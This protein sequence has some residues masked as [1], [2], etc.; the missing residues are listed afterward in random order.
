[1]TDVRSVTV[2]GDSVMKGVVYDEKRRKYTLLPENGADRASRA[3]GLQLRNRARMGCTVTKGLTIVKKDL[4]REPESEAALIEF[5]GNDCDFDWSAVAADPD[6]KHLPK[7]PLPAFVSQLHELV[8]LVV[9]KGVRPVL[10]TL[11]PIHAERYFAF[12]TR[13]GDNGT[14]GLDGDH[15]LKWLGDVQFIYR[16]HE[17]Y[18]NAVARVAEECGCILADVREAFLGE[19]HYEDLLCVDGIHP[20]NRGHA[21]MEQVLENFG[22]T[23]RD[24]GLIAI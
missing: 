23:C 21:L 9:Q 17:R 14:P 4:T 6:G 1:M 15:I 18:S 5:G 24:K 2:W 20:N 11:P 7:T 13:P 12:F 19:R 10:L 8:R 22:L 16:W 3:L